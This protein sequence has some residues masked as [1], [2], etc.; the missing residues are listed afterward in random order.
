MLTVSAI[1]SLH[2]SRCELLLW[3]WLCRRGNCR[4]KRHPARGWQSELK[5]DFTNSTT[6]LPLFRHRPRV[7]WYTCLRVGSAGVGQALGSSTVAIAIAP[8]RLGW[9]PAKVTLPVEYE[10][11]CMHRPEQT[12]PLSLSFLSQPLPMLIY[13]GVL[14]RHMLKIAQ[15]QLYSLQNS[16][17]TNLSH[18]RSS[19]Y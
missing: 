5:N 10:Q 1:V 6:L 11:K 2:C 15:P 3:A 18:L 7:S 16:G 12:S 9:G 4:S 19:N 17:V 14:G 8:W 13:G